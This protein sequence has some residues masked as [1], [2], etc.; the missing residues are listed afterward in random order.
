MQRVLILL[1]LSVWSS[2]CGGYYTLTCGDQ[3]AAAGG[4]AALVVRLQRNDFFVLNLPIKNAPMRFR[5][6]DGLERAGYTDKLGYAATTLP[7]SRTPGV[8][9]LHLDHM[10]FEGEET[11]AEARLYVLDPQRPAVATAADDLPMSDSYQGKCAQAALRNLAEKCNIIYLTRDP[12]RRHERI[13]DRLK[14]FGYP[15]GPVLLWQ[16][17]RWHIVRTG[18]YKI[19][20]VVVEARLV[21]QLPD[22]RKAFPKLS[23]GICR[24]P[25][26]AKAFRSAG[27]RPVVVGPAAKRF[28]ENECKSWEDLRKRGI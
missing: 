9:T 17:K 18:K 28:P 20:R 19:P 7:V 5:I 8:Y 27:I 3:I 4:D 24:S 1:L 12:I 22:L 10:D 11:A 15:D 23:D 2:G 16:R 6:D 25:I 14:K 13:R 21:S 26:A